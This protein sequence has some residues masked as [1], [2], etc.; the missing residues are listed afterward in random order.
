MDQDHLP[1]RHHYVPEFY[2]RSFTTEDG[3]FFVF[4]KKKDKIRKAYPKEYFFSW[5]RNT[6]FIGNEKSTL[7]ESLYGYFES[8]VA[9]HYEALK[10]TTNLSDFDLTSFFY[11]LR[12]IHFLYWRIPEND[13][14]LEKLIQEKAF[15]ETGFDIISKS[16][17]K[18]V[19]TLELQEQFKNVDL[20]RKMY[21]VFIPLLSSRPEYSKTDIENW[22]LYTRSDG[23]N[24]TGD[25][26]IIL[27]KYADF[28]NLNEELIFP[29]A[30][31]K[32]L[33]RTRR[34]KPSKL[35]A[36]FKLHLDILILQQATVYVCCANKE[37]LKLLVND[38]YSFSKNYDFREKMKD[39][40]FS[41][42]R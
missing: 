36:S 4:D 37:Y 29:L 17:G 9:P 40:V 28:S 11:V 19:A 23:N 31:N 22:R 25:T 33:V 7:L 8:T 35:P 30:K 5:N 34:D 41:H 18:S 27:E 3:V 12:F 39:S 15:I 32:I 2:L 24:L 20:F 42:F 38:L 6:G 21:R 1:Q 16:T 14:T 26:P 10:M 13:Y